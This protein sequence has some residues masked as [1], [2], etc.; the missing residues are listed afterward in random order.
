MVRGLEHVRERGDGESWACS[1]YG[2]GGVRR[3][4]SRWWK[5]ERKVLN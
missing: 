5:N 4:S 1:G 3:P 2:R